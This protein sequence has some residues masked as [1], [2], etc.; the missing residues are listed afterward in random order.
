MSGIT[1]TLIHDGYDP[2]DDASGAIIP[3]LHLSTTF[4]FGNKKEYDY[5]RSGNPTRD[6]LEKTLAAL[7]GANHAL[8][9][10]SGSAALAN[11]AALLK[12]GEEILFSS[13]AYGGTYRY[14]TSVLAR[15]GLK[16]HIVDFTDLQLVRQVVEQ[17]NIR[18]IWT[19]TPTNPLLKVAD[20]HGLADIAH[21]HD[22]LLVVD[23]TFLTPVAQRPIE[24][25]ADIV[26]YSTTKFIN[27]HSD[28][29]GGSLAVR[30]DALY[31]ELKF[32]QNAIGA[33]L[34][35][36][37][38]W[39]TLR[40]LRTLELRI[41]QHN[42]SARKIA[43]LLHDHPKIKRVYY[44]GLFEGEQGAIVKRQ[45]LLPGAIISVELVDEV[46]AQQFLGSL[47][48]F[49]LA[50]SLGGV[51]S[52]IDHPASMTHAA[53][54]PDER[55]KIGLSDRLF[56]ISVGIENT[57]DLVDDIQRSLEKV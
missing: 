7:D 28:S 39:L 46:D 57:D 20:I 10:S 53:I 30:D 48:Y 40:G 43:D 41:R 12:Q 2:S 25:G 8:T 22:A 36:F 1:T 32:L 13:D 6:A 5:S 35:P 11:V 55:A 33:I 34:S 31:E 9:Y 18:I 17:H 24:H 27:G 49:P 23:N 38:S 47:R 37:D 21:A 44:P 26:V 16:Y 52:L 14:V 19:E 4:K 56:R 51:E 15:T 3:P 50:E 29:I 54:P 42:E 45:Q